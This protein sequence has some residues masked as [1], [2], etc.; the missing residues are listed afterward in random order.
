MASRVTAAPAPLA[1]AWRERAV[2]WGSLGAI[3]LLAWLY[4]VRMPMT[5]GDL[6]GRAARILGAVAPGT[7]DAALMFMMWA[8]M[9]V[10]MMIPSAAPM[11]ETYARIAGGR[12]PRPGYRVG[13]FAAGYVTIW[14]AFSALATAAQ[15]E[16]QRAGMV[17]G[18]LT[19]TPVVSAILLFAAGIYQATPLKNLCLSKCRSP[20]G[21][22]LT[23]WREGAAGAYLMGL[24]HGATCV[25]C[26]A[27]LML[28][29]FV[30]GVMNLVWVAALSVLVVL[31][32][33]LPA[34]RLIARA[35]GYA[36]IA[37]GVALLL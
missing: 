37:G 29:L 27:M 2:L 21:F 10:A 28:L 17:T 18:A 33:S 15:V 35:S 36:M 9:M 23:E 26:C 16:L 5:P 20:L 22:L 11:I 24:H 12:G 31:E 19:A 34:G 30:F 32:K 14:T 13:L 7:A 3:T 25:G 6:G 4:L 8:V 1:I